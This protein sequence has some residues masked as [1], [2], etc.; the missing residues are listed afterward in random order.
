MADLHYWISGAL[1]AMQ[2][3]PPF[4]Q[5]YTRSGAAA[6]QGAEESIIPARSDQTNAVAIVA[7]VLNG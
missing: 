2:H 4:S 5:P 6:P 7:T 1:D 3:S